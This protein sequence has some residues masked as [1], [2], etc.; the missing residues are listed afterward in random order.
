[1][2]VCV[3][4]CCAYNVCIRVLLL[5]C[6]Y[7]FNSD[8]LYSDIYEK[9]W[10]GKFSAF[11]HFVGSVF[12]PSSHFTYI[13]MWF[14]G[15]RI[16]HHIAIVLVVVM[17]TSNFMDWLLNNSVFS[18]RLPLLQPS[19]FSTTE[20]FSLCQKLSFFNVIFW[21]QYCN[22]EKLSSITLDI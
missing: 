12:L 15:A 14:L 1:M 21:T 8:L 20:N 9:W 22:H 17:K 6:C 2:Y 16:R 19:F 4:V 13:K 11:K 7:Y 10:N 5:L 18:F 3:C